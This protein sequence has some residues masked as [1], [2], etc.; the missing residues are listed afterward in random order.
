MIPNTRQE[1]FDY[2]IRHLLEQGKRSMNGGACK[3]RA[4]DDRCA[5]GWIIPDYLYLEEMDDPETAWG[6]GDMVNRDI[7]AVVTLGW[8]LA[9]AMQDAHDTAGDHIPGLFKTTLLE[10]MQ[11]VA[12]NYNLAWNFEEIP[13]DRA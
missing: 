6:V 10:N 11:E 13:D 9:E 1:I 4:G 7:P 2:I 5:I 3:Y 8:G 12:R